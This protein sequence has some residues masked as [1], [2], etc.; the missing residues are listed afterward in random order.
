[1]LAAGAV[2][3]GSLPLGDAFDRLVAL[4]AR[5][6]CLSVHLGVQFK[7]STGFAA[8]TL[9]VLQGCAAGLNRCIKRGL[10]GLYKAVAARQ[11]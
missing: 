11:G 5:L 8:G 2:I 7:I 9:V 3:G 1:M 4:W 10:Y 6:A